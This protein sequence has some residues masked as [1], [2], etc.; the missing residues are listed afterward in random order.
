MCDGV[1]SE[2]DPRRLH[3]GDAIGVEHVVAANPAR[4]QKHGRRRVVALEEWKCHVVVVAPAVI[5]GQRARWTGDLPPIGH[6]VAKRIDRHE[7]VARFQ[8]AQ[9]VF[10][11]AGGHEHARVHVG[12]RVRQHTVIH[13]HDAVI[14]H[15]QT[16]ALPLQTAVVRRR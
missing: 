8:E 4:D 12:A 5:E 9:M 13:Q 6:P 10:E 2:R 15:R 16:M 1:R 7:L 11:R 3:A 14:L